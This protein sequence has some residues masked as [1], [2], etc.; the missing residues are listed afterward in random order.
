[1]KWTAKRIDDDTFYIENGERAEY[2][3]GAHC[4]CCALLI[5]ISQYGGK[6]DLRGLFRYGICYQT[7]VVV[8]KDKI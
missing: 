3:R 2:I 5:V 7:L 8:Q 6:A 1:M 4:K